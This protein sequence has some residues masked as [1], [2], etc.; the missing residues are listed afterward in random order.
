MKRKNNIYTIPNTKIKLGS[1]VRFVYL[2]DFT[3]RYHKLHHYIGEDEL[4]IS[5]SVLS[6]RKEPNKGMFLLFKHGVPY[7]IAI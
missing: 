2:S 4:G 6:V 7:V 5:Y 1:I 3:H